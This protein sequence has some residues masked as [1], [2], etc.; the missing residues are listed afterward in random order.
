[1]SFNG[2][3][4]IL[5]AVGDSFCTRVDVSASYAAALVYPGP[6]IDW[7]EVNAAIIERWSLSGLEFIK[8]EAWKRAKAHP[9]A[10]NHPGLTAIG[11]TVGSD[12]CG[13][14]R[15]EES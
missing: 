14:S 6:E 4:L 13:C 3:H 10:D 2:Q 15:A 5:D 1:M 11:D 7:H 8:R 9:H 12:V